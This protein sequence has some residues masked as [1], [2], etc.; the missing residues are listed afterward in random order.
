MDWMDKVGQ[1]EWDN[2]VHGNEE[3]G[4]EENVGKYG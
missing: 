4:K 2:Q 1:L 3:E